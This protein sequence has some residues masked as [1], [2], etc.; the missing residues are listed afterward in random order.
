[1]LG[2]K[3]LTCQ[4]VTYHVGVSMLVLI[5]VFVDVLPVVY[6]L[7]NDILYD[8]FSLKITIIE[9]ASIGYIITTCVYTDWVFF[10]GFW[11]QRTIAHNVTHTHTQTH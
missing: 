7:N 2:P 11:S 3:H 6:F 5:H 4:F 1:M 9:P 10:T 8:F